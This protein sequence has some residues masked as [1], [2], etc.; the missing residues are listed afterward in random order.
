MNI[1]HVTRAHDTESK[2]GIHKSLFPIVKALRNR[3]HSVE[4]LDQGLASRIALRPWESWL[5]KSYCAWMRTRLG[6]GAPTAWQ[7]VR[8][9][10]DVGIR[11]AKIAARDKVT[12]VHCHDPLLGYMYD[13]FRKIYRSSTNWGI[14]EHAY[15]RFV[16]I[17][18]G[19]EIDSRSLN[20][21]QKQELQATQKARWV[22]FPTKSG[23]DRFFKDVPLQAPLSNCHI[24]PHAIDIKLIER[25]LAREKLNIKKDEKL[26]IAAGQLIPMKRFDLLLQAAALLPRTI[27]PKIIILGEG[28]EYQT[29]VKQA[30][31]LNLADHVAITSTDHIGE[32]LSAADVY[33]STSATEA[34][35]MANC[36]A[37][38]AGVP[39]VLTAVDAVPELAGDAALLVTD[40][41]QTIAEAIQSILTSKNV[42]QQ[43]KTNAAARIALWQSPE[44]IADKMI[45]IYDKTC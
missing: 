25:A 39:S 45:K 37:L 28:P 10:V 12:H 21:L 43:L 19:I 5:V 6:K 4:V 41:P 35:G 1:L 29:L 30:A 8:E 36:E 42:Q 17:R 3:G 24:V 18:P 9:R 15:G 23:M 13:H 27:I 38:A 16:A 20:I 34:F 32:H 2:Y 26:L 14:T 22:L 44:A 7:V 40:D 33:V 31:A 11:A